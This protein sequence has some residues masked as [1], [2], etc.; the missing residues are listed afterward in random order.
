M[1]FIVADVAQGEEVLSGVLAAFYVGDS[2]VKLQ[3]PGGRCTP[4]LTA[5]PAAITTGIIVTVHD[6]IAHGIGDFSI[7]GRGLSRGLKD[8]GAY[9]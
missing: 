8:I 1:P 9:G 4:I 7:L 3:V 5:V 6:R 2:V